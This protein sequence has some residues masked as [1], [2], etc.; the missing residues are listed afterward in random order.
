M[1][2]SSTINADE[3]VVYGAMIQGQIVTQRRDDVV[4][5]FDSTPLSLGLETVG[6]LLQVLI[7]RGLFIPSKRSQIFT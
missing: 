7:P 2:S 4:C 3:A 5:S 1:I 6:G